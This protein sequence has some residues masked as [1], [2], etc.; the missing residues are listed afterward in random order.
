MLHTKKNHTLKS[1]G[2]IS[3]CFSKYAT[4]G[5]IGGRWTLKNGGMWAVVP[6]DKWEKGD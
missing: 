2:G 5:G 3:Q 6:Q 4:G 1:T